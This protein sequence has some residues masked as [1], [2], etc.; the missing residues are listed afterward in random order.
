M[1]IEL[2]QAKIQ[3]IH[4]GKKMTVLKMLI[5]T[6]PVCASADNEMNEAYFCYKCKGCGT[7]F[8]SI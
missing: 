8:G 1:T 7:L 2:K 5:P 3:E 4:G 6:C